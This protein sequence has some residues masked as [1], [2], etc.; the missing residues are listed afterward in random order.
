M[1]TFFASRSEEGKVA[2][3]LSKILGRFL[4]ALTYQACPAFWRTVHKTWSDSAS[5]QPGLP[6]CVLCIML[7]VR[8]LQPGEEQIGTV[9]M[10]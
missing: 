2:A 9:N 5:I 3:K 7:R 6:G 4:W 10:I 8:C 1:P